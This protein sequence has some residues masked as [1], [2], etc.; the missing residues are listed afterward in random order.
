MRGNVVVLREKNMAKM[1][2]TVEENTIKTCDPIS[3]THGQFE[4][5]F[6]L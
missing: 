3:V 1:S 2:T 5:T 6:L 4:P